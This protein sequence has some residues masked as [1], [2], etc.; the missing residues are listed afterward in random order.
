[1]QV[2]FQAVWKGRKLI[3]QCQQFAAYCLQAL[4]VICWGKGAKKI[5]PVASCLKF[6]TDGL[7]LCWKILGSAN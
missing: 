5:N 3:Y 6:A 4:R 1:M 7:H 2:I